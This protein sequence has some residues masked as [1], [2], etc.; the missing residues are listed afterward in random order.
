MLPPPGNTVPMRLRRHLAL[1]LVALGVMCASATLAAPAAADLVLTNAR[2]FTGDPA[3]PWAEAVA[4]KGERII[5]V[6]TVSE[7]RAKDAQPIPSTSAGGCW[8]PASTT[9]TTTLAPS[10][11]A[12]RRRPGA[13]PWRI[14]LWP[15]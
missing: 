3:R 13:R 10:L 1:L 6:G 4:I 12:S 15:R 2:V 11:L 8:S 7:I 5:A 14:R 9:R